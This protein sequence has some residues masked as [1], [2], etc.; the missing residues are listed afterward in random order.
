MKCGDNNKVNRIQN[1]KSNE[2]IQT[3]AEQHVT[4]TSTKVTTIIVHLI[5][6]NI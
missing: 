3:G 2:K 6:I 4:Q 5:N 1:Q